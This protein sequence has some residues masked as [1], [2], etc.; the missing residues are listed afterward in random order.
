MKEKIKIV[1]LEKEDKFL[2]TITPTAEHVFGLILLL[3]RNY[4]DAIKSIEKGL[5][6]RRKFGGY[7][8][9]S[10]L[11][12]GIIG[13]GRLGKITKRISDGFKMKSYICDVNKNNYR[14]S[15]KT[16]FKN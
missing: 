16:L 12:I 8:M 14:S 10:Q 7:A 3:T 5:F 9:L 2:K 4:Q 15:L 13:Y 6:N 1:C 11:K